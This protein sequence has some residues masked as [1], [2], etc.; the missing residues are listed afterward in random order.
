MSTFDQLKYRVYIQVQEWTGD[1][2]ENVFSSEQVCPAFRDA[3][4]I[5]ESEFDRFGQYLEEVL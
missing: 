3:R 2:F 1:K 4:C 5:V